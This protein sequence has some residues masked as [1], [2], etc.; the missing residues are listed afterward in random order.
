[1]YKVKLIEIMHQAEM[2]GKWPENLRYSTVTLTPKPKATH[3]GQL[4]PIG[5]LPTIYRIWMSVRQPQAY[6]WTKKH[7]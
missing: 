4:R 7:L 2:E 1:M 5:L 3:K 6:E